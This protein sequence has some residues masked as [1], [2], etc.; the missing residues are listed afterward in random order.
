MISWYFAPFA[1]LTSDLTSDWSAGLSLRPI[2]LADVQLIRG[3]NVDRV[4]IC[5]EICL[6]TSSCVTNKKQKK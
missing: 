5:S 1:P 2:N 6:L 4:E 3:S